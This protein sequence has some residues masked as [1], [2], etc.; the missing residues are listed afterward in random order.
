MSDL[1][2]VGSGCEG[3]WYYVRGGMGAVSKAIATSATAFGAEILVGQVRI[4][5]SFLLLK[6][7]Y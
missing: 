6:L 2:G 4:E 5:Y 7:L 1:C 3:A